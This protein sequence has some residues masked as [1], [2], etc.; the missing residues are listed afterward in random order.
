M[1]GGYNIELSRKKAVKSPLGLEYHH[2]KC[3]EDCKMVTPVKTENTIPTYL[4][5]KDERKSVGFLLC[6]QSTFVDVIA[7]FPFLF[8]YSFEFSPK[9][10]VRR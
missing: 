10:I 6:I 5:R 7:E 2:R 1:R 3:K 9:D 4:H 8:C